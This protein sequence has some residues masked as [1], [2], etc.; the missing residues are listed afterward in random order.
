MTGN[1]A[2]DAIERDH[3][4]FHRAEHEVADA[5][6]DLMR[7]GH[8]DQHDQHDQHDAPQPAATAPPIQAV[9][10][11][12][13]TEDNMQLWDEIKD[14]AEQIAGKVAQVDTAMID[15]AEKIG[16][17]PGAAEFVDALLSAGHVPPSLI[18]AF[19][20]LAKEVALLAPRPEAD[21]VTAAIAAQAAGGPA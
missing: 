2:G 3:G 18:T 9:P 19:T 11:T 16:A 6:R 21:P 17:I 12:P 13:T 20:G 5:M 14:H 15:R 8:H 7:P 10:A 4:W 1:P